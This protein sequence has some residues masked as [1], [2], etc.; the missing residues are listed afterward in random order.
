[1]H[2]LRFDDIVL[3]RPVLVFESYVCPNC[4]HI[5]F[6]EPKSEP[7]IPGSFDDRYDLT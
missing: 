1:M 6:F 7:P 4:G 2:R 3:V 5:E